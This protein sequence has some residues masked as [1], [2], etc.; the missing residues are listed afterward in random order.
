MVFTFLPCGF[1]RLSSQSQKKERKVLLRK[2]R[3]LGGRSCVALDDRAKM[4]LE[5]LV[6]Y[7]REER[8]QEAWAEWEETGEGTNSQGSRGEGD[9]EKINA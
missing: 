6:T 7:G 8:I 4:N 5:D 2:V 1:H 9:L 3:D